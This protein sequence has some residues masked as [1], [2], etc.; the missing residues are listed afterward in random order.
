MARLGGSRLSDS[1]ASI[2]FLDL[3]EFG[4]KFQAILRPKAMPSATAREILPRRPCYLTGVGTTNLR[5]AVAVGQAGIVDSTGPDLPRAVL[6]IAQ[7]IQDD[8]RAFAER[9]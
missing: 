4:R 9:L 6:G 5:L 7:R 2:W 3:G 1:A 8:D